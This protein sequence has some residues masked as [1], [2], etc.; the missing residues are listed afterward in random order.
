MPGHV[1]EGLER[2]LL[3]RSEEAKSRVVPPVDYGQAQSIAALSE[4]PEDV[5]VST[6]IVHGTATLS[7]RRRGSLLL[8]RILGLFK[9][10]G[11]LQFGRKLL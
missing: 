7:S 3:A 4:V 1:S 5:T 8:R 11:I 2:P 9:P 10:E 6:R